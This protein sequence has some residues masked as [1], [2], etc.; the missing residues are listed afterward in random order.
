MDKNPLS[1][2]LESA[3]SHYLF[4]NAVRI[5]LAKSGDKPPLQTAELLA[6]FDRALES[7]GVLHDK[8]EDAAGTIAPA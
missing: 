8:L 6:L 3:A 2:V 4:L 5:L 1:P 7:A